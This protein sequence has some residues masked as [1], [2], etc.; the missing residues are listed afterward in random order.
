MNCADG[1]L[2]LIDFTNDNE[3]HIVNSVE[4]G[5]RRAQEIFDKYCMEILH[6]IYQ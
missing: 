2:R 6:N 3:K 4:D 5:K 1:K